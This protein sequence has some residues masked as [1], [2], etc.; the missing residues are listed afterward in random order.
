MWQLT[1]LVSLGLGPWGQDS[2]KAKDTAGAS[3]QQ[4]LASRQQTD[5]DRE[6]WVPLFN[7]RNLDGWYTY[8]QKH[9]KNRD[10]DHV[11]AI[12]DGAIHLYKD[13]ADGSNVVMGYIAT[14]KEHG[15]YH[16]RFQYR[17]G[18][19]KFEPRYKLKRDAGLYYHLNGP[20]AVWPRGLQY[21]IQQTDVGDLL[22][23]HGFALDTWIDP[24]TA[25]EKEATYKDPK[26]G[27]Q[28][29]VL[30]QRGIG[31]QRRLPG[32]FEVDDW[33]TAEVIAKGDTTVHLLNGQLVNQGRG[34]RYA[35]PSKPNTAQPVTKGRIAL[36][37]EAAEI[38]FRKVELRNLD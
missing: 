18:T 16:L 37:I 28:P 20:D 35:D 1:V 19:K 34:V 14:E 30:G 2:G 38:F 9:G 22:A 36:E 3:A 25:S 10:P 23:L 11:I 13:A 33:N 17:W 7:G 5:P 15:N 26:E 4:S 12:E 32:E 29:R 24:K 6:R 21:Q 31:Y 8:L 27:G